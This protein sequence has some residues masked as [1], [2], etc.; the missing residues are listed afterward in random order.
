MS[1]TIDL[2]ETIVLILVPIT[3]AIT[4][5]NILLLSWKYSMTSIEKQIS[6]LS[7]WTIIPWPE[8]FVGQDTYE[9]FYGMNY[10]HDI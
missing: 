3:Y 6:K 1:T 8:R 2:K 9:V 5:Q 4:M 7:K 10:S